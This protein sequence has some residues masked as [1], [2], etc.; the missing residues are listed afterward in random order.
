MSDRVLTEAQEA[1]VYFQPR[2]LRAY[3]LVESRTDAGRLIQAADSN[4]KQV[5]ITHIGADAIPQD[6]QNWY[7][8]LLTAPIQ[9]P[10]SNTSVI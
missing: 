8:T 4:G 1:V 5:S 6:A 2:G 7:A 9:Q 10:A 3:A